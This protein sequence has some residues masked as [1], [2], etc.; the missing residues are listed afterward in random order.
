MA[1]ANRVATRGKRNGLFIIHGHTG[2][3]Q[4]DVLR[5]T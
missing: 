2:K 3:R 5:R 1:L 4:A